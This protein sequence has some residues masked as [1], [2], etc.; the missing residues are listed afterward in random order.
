MSAAILTKYFDRL[1][2]LSGQRWHGEVTQVL[3]QLVESNGPLCSAG[4]LCEVWDGSGRRYLGQIIG[5][6]GPTVLSMTFETPRHVRFG[7]HVVTWGARPQV[8]VGDR[9][10]GRV[11]DALGAPID[12]LGNIELNERRDLEHAAPH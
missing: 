6:R 4:E 1:N 10:I 9:I 7:D 3:G 11:I 5:F 8:T 2:T 12:G